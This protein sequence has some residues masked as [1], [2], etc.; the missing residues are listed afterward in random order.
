MTVLMTKSMKY[1]RFTRT[2]LF[3]MATKSQH[4][5]DVVLQRV[6]PK[7]DNLYLDIFIELP[8]IFPHKLKKYE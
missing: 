5:T 4:K 3:R 7:V 6:K 8:N 1:T 2:C